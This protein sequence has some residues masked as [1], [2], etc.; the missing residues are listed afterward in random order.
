MRLTEFGFGPDLGLPRGLLAVNAALLAAAVLGG[1]AFGRGAAVL[2]A[3]ATFGAVV[4][5]REYGARS[6]R[7]D[8]RMHR[9]VA[10]LS[11]GEST[12]FGWS[13]ERERRGR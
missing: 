1:L 2:F 13:W 8:R 4:S 11:E 7:R 9:E 5:V 3:A 10:R 6:R 12:P